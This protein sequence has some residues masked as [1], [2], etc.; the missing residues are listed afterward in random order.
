ML[1][2]NSSAKFKRLALRHWISVFDTQYLIQ[3]NICVYMY[4]YI[5]GVYAVITQT[6]LSSIWWPGA[7]L[8]HLLVYI[9][10]S[11]LPQFVSNISVF[12]CLTCGSLKDETFASSRHT[13]RKKIKKKEKEKRRASKPENR[14]EKNGDNFW[15]ISSRWQAPRITPDKLGAQK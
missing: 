5:N 7:C 4:M 10:S 2:F 12:S 1:I 9:C 8:F 15:H 11:F 14:E 3:S 13:K 6:A